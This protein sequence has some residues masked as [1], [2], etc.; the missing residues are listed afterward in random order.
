MSG[1]YAGPQAYVAWAAGVVHGGG[2]WGAGRCARAAFRLGHDEVLAYTFRAHSQ[3]SHTHSSLIPV[4]VLRRPAATVTAFA[5]KFGLAM[6]MLTAL[7]QP[8]LLT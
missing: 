1:Q 7:W 5:G 6:L 2:G 3:A 8:A 4:L